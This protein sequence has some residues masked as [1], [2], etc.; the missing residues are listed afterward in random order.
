MIKDISK[1]IKAKLLNVAK[2]QNLDYQQLITR[3]LY[4][5]LLFRLSISDYRDKFYLK[6]GALLYAIENEM[7]RP[8][9][10]IDFLGVRVQNDLANIKHVFTE[11]CRIECIED[12]VSIDTDSIETTE[13]TEE[14]DYAGI[15]VS[16]VASLHTIRQIMKMDIGF[17]DIVTPSAQRLT[18]PSFIESLPQADILAYSLESV[19]A[20]KFQ[21]MIDL[22]VFNSRYKDFYDVY[23]I[24]NSSAINDMVL[25]EAIKATFRNRGTRYRP[26][27][28]L[29]SEDFAKDTERNKQWT[30]FLKRI[31][32]TGFQEFDVVMA[33]IAE[34][35]E[36]IYQTID[37]E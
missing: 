18:Y 1:S 29:F 5:R 22:S 34:R 9:K 28:P 24:L 26:N 20:E 14:K 7:P 13:I 3:Y 15:R 19:V 6:G 16:F 27:H 23:K 2:E 17:G 8:T 36:P 25:S 35:L 10:D 37:K 21:A 12:G 31:K 30:Q 32:Q 11:I 33:L 4:E